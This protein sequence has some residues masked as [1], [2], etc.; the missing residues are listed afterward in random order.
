VKS[1]IAADE[2]LTP[3]VLYIGVGTLTGSIITR[4]RSRFL[5]FLVPP[6]LFF[7]SLHHFL[8]KT[9]ANLSDYLGSLED[10]YVPRVAQIH[11]VSNAHTAMTWE[12]IKSTTRD[13]REKL[14]NGV[15]GIVGK[16]QEATGLKL[17]EGLGWSKDTAK[18]VQVAV[19]EKT[20]AVVD[21]VEK[22]AQDAKKTVEEKVDDVKRLV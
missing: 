16:V 5:R 13:G 7:L 3:A 10:K 9:S 6:T 17:Q 12:M 22:G 4:N 21:V 19:E 2:T 14:S 1:I 18:V 11:D 8:P 20:K 15:V